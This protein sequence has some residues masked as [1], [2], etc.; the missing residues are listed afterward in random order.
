MPKLPKKN[1]LVCTISLPCGS[2]DWCAGIEGRTSLLPKSLVLSFST[3]RAQ[4]HSLLTAESSI[5]NQLIFINHPRDKSLQIIKPSPQSLRSS[6]EFL[7]WGTNWSIYFPSFWLPLAFSGNLV[8]L[9]WIPRILLHRPP[10]P[11]PLLAPQQNIIYRILK[12]E[13]IVSDINLWKKSY[14]DIKP[15]NRLQTKTN[16]LCFIFSFQNIFK[17][18]SSFSAI[19]KDLWE[20]CVEWS[21]VVR[22][23]KTRKSAIFCQNISS[24]FHYD[25]FTNLWSGIIEIVLQ[26]YWLECS[27][28]SHICV[29]NGFK[30]EE[31]GQF[32]VKLKVKILGGGKF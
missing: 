7:D 21:R 32:E 27:S 23:P 4:N 2:I 25:I 22:K 6:G 14:A 16:L 8:V 24:F 9:L 10:P 17:K 3:H 1:L 18:L 26:Y 15:F 20:R 28:I 11:Q 12:E 5:C 30:V 31:G 13:N 29:Q 19:L